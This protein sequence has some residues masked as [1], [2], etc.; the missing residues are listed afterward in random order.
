M[1]LLMGPGWLKSRKLSARFEIV[2][3]SMKI[4]MRGKAH[5]KSVLVKYNTTTLFRDGIIAAVVVAVYIMP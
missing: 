3:F 4:E 5:Y 1:R 2:C